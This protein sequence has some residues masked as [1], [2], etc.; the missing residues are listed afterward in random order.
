AFAT[1]MA[2]GIW[3]ELF[4]RS[5]PKS[6]NRPSPRKRGEGDNPQRVRLGQQLGE[7]ADD[8]VGPDRA[9]GGQAGS[10][11]VVPDRV[12][13]EPLRGNDL[14]FEVVADHPCLLRPDA[15]CLHSMGV[16]T[17]LRFAEAVLSLDLNM[18]EPLFEGEAGHLRALRLGGAIGDERQSYTELFEAIE[19]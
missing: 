17:F 6:K 19:R 10:V 12:D 18:V 16:G 8:A 4:E 3:T 13:P 5:C 2:L 11:A 15:E 14:P 7:R 9:T 1:T